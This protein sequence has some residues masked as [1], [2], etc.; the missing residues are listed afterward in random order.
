[1]NSAIKI[2]RKFQSLQN[3]SKNRPNYILCNT[4]TSKNHFYELGKTERALH[5]K[6]WYFMTSAAKKEFLTSIHLADCGVLSLSYW[7][8]FFRHLIWMKKIC[9]T[10]CGLG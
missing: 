1:V 7:Y 8:T 4:F 9:Q 6:I 3:T 2:V 10:A 5:V